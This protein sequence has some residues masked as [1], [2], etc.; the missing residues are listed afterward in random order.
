[1][2]D[3]I[4][5]A[6]ELRDRSARPDFVAP[7]VLKEIAERIETVT[8]RNGLEGKEAREAE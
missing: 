5:L 2:N 1:M 8:N 7:S 4:R 3:L 6:Q